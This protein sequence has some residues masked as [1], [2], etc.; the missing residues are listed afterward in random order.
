[1]ARMSGMAARILALLVVAGAAAPAGE[2]G[3]AGDAGAGREL[4]WRY[5]SACH[6]ERADGMGPM[7][8]VLTVKP[9]N[10]TRLAAGNGGV[11]PLARVIARIDGRDPMIAHGSEMPVYGD[12][13]LEG[14][15]VTL[16]AE[17]GSG[18]RIRTSGAVAD[19]VAYLQSIQ[20]R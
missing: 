11:F 12:F 6:G 10:L 4:Y 3:E 2:A 8:P 15:S 19:L 1:M 14:G 16:S 20:A 7:R 5:C 13:F 17:D 9:A 18:A